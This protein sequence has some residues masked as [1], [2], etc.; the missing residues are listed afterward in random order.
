MAAAGVVLGHWLTYVFAVPDAQVRTEILAASGHSY[1]LLAIKAA[2]VLTV[3]L[4]HLGAATR[5]EPTVADRLIAL[6]ARLSIAQL[7]AFT[8]MEVAERI[9]AG[10]PVAAMFGHHLFVLGLAVQIVVAFAGA[11]FLLW[12]GRAAARIC[13]AITARSPSRA[14][15]LGARPSLLLVRPV[16]VLA[17][18]GG[19]R[20]P[21]R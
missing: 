19:V 6:A 20:G 10:T 13:Q 11:F 17:G 3:F 9:A 5:G 21:P 15:A 8:A 7:V 1:W 12:F 4:R 14:A 16:P 2:V 18:A